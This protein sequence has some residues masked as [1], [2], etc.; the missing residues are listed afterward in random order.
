MDEPLISAAAAFAA[1]AVAELYT[2]I[3]DEAY[4][5]V[6]LTRIEGSLT[7]D[8]VVDGFD[9]PLYSWNML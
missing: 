1:A 3:L 6:V 5:C 4:D 8:P 2:L 7:V 9:G